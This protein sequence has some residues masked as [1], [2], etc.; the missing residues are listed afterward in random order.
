MTKLIQWVILISPLNVDEAVTALATLVAEDKMV[1]ESSPVDSDG[2]PIVW[3]L[4]RDDRFEL[5]GG[6][7]RKSSPIVLLDL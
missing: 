1:L 4:D 5:L 2:K 6:G 3:C 7:G